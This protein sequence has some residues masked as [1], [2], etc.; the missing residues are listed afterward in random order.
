[1]KIIGYCDGSAIANGKANARASWGYTLT[2]EEA[3]VKYEEE[4]GALVEGEIQTNQRAEMTAMIKLCTRA[5]ELMGK[6]PIATCEINSDS[7]YCINCYQQ[8]WYIKWIQN[9]WFKANGQAVLNVDLWKQLIP[10][11]ENGNFIFKK[12]KGHSGINGNEKADI[13]ARSYNI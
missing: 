4:Q 3:G 10:F 11:F 12:I 8:K 2:Y 9:N 13:I 5:Q 7:A 1:M 6:R